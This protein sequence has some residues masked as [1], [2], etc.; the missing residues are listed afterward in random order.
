MNQEIK[1]YILLIALDNLINT[2]KDVLDIVQ[3]T[4]EETLFIEQIINS[5]QEIYN[6]MY[7]PKIQ[8]PKW[9]EKP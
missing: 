9:N 8:K 3:L 5:A 6:E 1:N 7:N 4:T 2:Y